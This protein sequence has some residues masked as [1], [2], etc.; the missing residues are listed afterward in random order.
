M[1]DGMRKTTP[2]V[3]LDVL[4]R[5]PRL[6]TYS[7]KTIKACKNISRYFK[8]NLSERSIQSV[9][10]GAIKETGIRKTTLH[11]PI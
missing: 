9:F 11:V 4:T 6:R 10:E 7:Y 5:N 8:R 1:P 2:Q 3:S